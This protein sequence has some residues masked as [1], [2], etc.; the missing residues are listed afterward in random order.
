[1]RSAA[2]LVRR[3]IRVRRT[4]VPRAFHRLTPASTDF[5][6]DR[7]TPIDRYYIERALLECAPDIQ[8]RV[9]EIKDDTYTR[10]FG[11]TRV[12]QSDVLDVIADNPCATIIADL[13][14]APQIPS[15]TFDCVIVTQTLQLIDELQCAIRTLHRVLKPG[16]ILLATVPGISQVARDGFN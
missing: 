5:G 6:Y 16:G 7:G 13:R 11:G 1:L 8:G 9:L 15:D 4:R 3:N 12:T 14:A 2:R 10:R